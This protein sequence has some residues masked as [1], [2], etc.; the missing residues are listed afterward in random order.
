MTREPVD[1]AA[2][3]KIAQ[4]LRRDLRLVSDADNGVKAVP[5]LPTDGERYSQEQSRAS[6]QDGPPA[7]PS[8][9]AVAEEN[10]P[11]VWEA[12]QPDEDILEVS[13]TETVTPEQ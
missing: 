5:V 7:M 1:P 11:S 4:G 10:A 8:P 13:D 6:E 3:P 2:T 9:G 12:I